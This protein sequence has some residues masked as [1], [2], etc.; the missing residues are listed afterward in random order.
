MGERALK[1]EHAQSIQRLLC[2]DGLRVV[3]R[4]VE[5]AE[6]GRA[7]KSDPALFALAMA[8]AAESDAVRAAALS[9][10]LRVAR[11][12]THLF[13]F[14][15]FVQAQRG[16]GRGLRRAVS[17]WYNNR[18]LDELAYQTVKY[19]QRDGWRHRD[20]LRL[21]HPLVNAD[22]VAR[23][24]LYGWILRQEPHAELPR[25]VEGFQILDE[26]QADV[27]A[28][29][30]IIAAYGLPRE[31]VPSTLLKEASIWMA[32]LERMPLTAM[33]RNLEVMASLGMLTP[34][35]EATRQV[36]AALGNTEALRRARAHPLAI[37]TA[38]RIYS[39]GRGLRGSLT[40]SPTP[41]ITAA[42][43]AAFFNAFSNVAPTG[44]RILLALDVSGS[45]D[46][47]NIAASPL[48]PREAS[49]AMALVTARVEP[50]VRI[51]A[52]CHKLR[53]LNLSKAHG[54]DDVVDR[55]R[56]LPFGGTD[57]AQ[58]MLYAL[59]HDLPVDCFIVYTDSETWAGRVSP[60]KALRRYRERTGIDAKLVVV[61]MLSNGFSIADPND[62]GMLDVVGFDTAAP[63]VI[64]Q[65]IQSS[66]EAA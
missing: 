53:E 39:A 42:L 14:A 35:A 41:A 1:R 23:R 62:G 12:G 36:V 60:V 28:S 30:E 59:K 58:P 20:L 61:G 13:H 57:C 37:L 33:L 21:A 4:I 27:I 66:A 9:A 26:A 17:A 40:W 5:I 48:T 44:R 52:F 6:S 29:A 65:F 7:P 34:D 3:R 10:L 22:D 63:A 38:L 49:A 55:V 2:A 15:A 51:V 31:A 24:A 16:W 43:E 18:P 25:L 46:W 32:L 45:M 47:G 11:T 8:C 19:R 56:R 64:N 54:V 50:E